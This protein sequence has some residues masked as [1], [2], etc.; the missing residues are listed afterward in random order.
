MQW[1]DLHSAGGGF[2]ASLGAG[3]GVCPFTAVHTLFNKST[4]SSARGE[5]AAIACL[6]LSHLIRRLR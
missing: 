2:G 4:G 6:V 1:L 3:L 5:I